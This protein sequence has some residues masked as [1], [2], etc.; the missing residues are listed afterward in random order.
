MQAHLIDIDL[1]NL[2]GGRVNGASPAYGVDEMTHALKTAE[3]KYFMTVPS[4]IE[5][6]LT[7]AKLAGILREHIFLLEGELEGFTTMKQLLDIGRSYSKDDQAPIY[8]IPSGKK[9]SEVCGY[10]NFSSGTTGLPKAVSLSDYYA[11]L[12]LPDPGLT[13]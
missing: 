12:V 6:A 8:Q 4:Q 7:A 2:A 3:T 9:N 13:T 5:V 11:Q 1:C 10:L